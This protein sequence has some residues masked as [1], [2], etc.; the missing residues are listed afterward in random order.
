MNGISAFYSGI[1]LR[2]DGMFLSHV[3]LVLQNNAFAYA[4]KFTPN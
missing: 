3:L 4:T 1:L 2:Y